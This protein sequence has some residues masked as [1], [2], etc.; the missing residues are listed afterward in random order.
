MITFRV[1]LP[2]KRS[3]RGVLRCLLLSGLSRLGQSCGCQ[4][5]HSRG[6]LMLL[7]TP[8]A[9]RRTVSVL[10]FAWYLLI[11][12]ADTGCCKDFPKQ[13]GSV[14]IKRGVRLCLHVLPQRLLFAL[15]RSVEEH[16][17]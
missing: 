7:P 14:Y 10:L 6:S 8:Q 16:P 5:G 13:G 1:A 11:A 3:D 17:S 4:V 15:T 2:S 12:T 9:V